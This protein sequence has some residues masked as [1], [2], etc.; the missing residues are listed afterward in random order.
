MEIKI[1][2]KKDYNQILEWLNL[3]YLRDGE[4]MYAQ[5]DTVLKKCFDNKN[6]LVC[7]DSEGESAIGF[8]TMDFKIMSVKC[9]YRMRGIGRLLVRSYLDEYI[10]KDV[11]CLYINSAT[12]KSTLFWKKM[13]AKF[14]EC[15]NI[16]YLKINKDY[17]LSN[18]GGSCKDVTIKFYSEMKLH[19]D[20][21]LPMKVYGRKGKLD[22]GY[23]RLS[24]D[25]IYFNNQEINKDGCVEI[26][27]DG[28]QIEL[29]KIKYSKSLDKLDCLPSSVFVINC[30][31]L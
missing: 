15:R 30:I 28:K 31:Y 5:R 18:I 25:V 22:N 8:L 24:S 26:V 1:A 3:E 10:D 13:G 23:L 2:N 17:S 9:D 27:V 29:S 20:S 21:L 12:K 14:Y 4:G 16:G 6:I 11:R 19:K 7:I